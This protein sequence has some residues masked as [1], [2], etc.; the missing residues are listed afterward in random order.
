LSELS[1]NPSGEPQPVP[2]QKIERDGL[3]IHISAGSLDAPTK[4]IETVV[5]SLFDPDNWKNPTKSF[6]TTDEG[7][8]NDVAYGLDW[9]TGGHETV[10]LAGG[11]SRVTS[12]G[13]YYYIGS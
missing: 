3:V 9:F 13:Y 7:V 4:E 11:V 10:C 2:T 1:S 8:A 5:H 12:L 6:D